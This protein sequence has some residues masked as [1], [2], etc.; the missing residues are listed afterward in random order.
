M[1]IEDDERI[2]DI[3]SKIEE[4]L[5]KRSELKQAQLENDEEIRQLEGYLAFLLQKP[6]SEISIFKSIPDH[7][8]AILKARGHPMKAKEL[9]EAIRQIPAL[10][11]TALQTVTG[12]LIRL[13]NKKQRFE[14]VAPNTYYLRKEGNM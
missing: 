10:E 1:T 8:E 13:A 3:K 14:R 7:L 9:L 11:N 6:I 12:A 2:A 4:R 5:S